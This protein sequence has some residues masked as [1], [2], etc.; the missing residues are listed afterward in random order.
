[1][2][3]WFEENWELG[4][5]RIGVFSAI[6]AIVLAIILSFVFHHF[7]KAAEAVKSAFTVVGALAIGFAAVIQL[8]RHQI[9]EDD[10]ERAEERAEREIAQAQSDSAAKFSERLSKAVSH[11]FDGTL[12]V[13]CGAIFEFRTLI[14]D[15]KLWENLD[16]IHAILETSI[17]DGLENIRKQGK[18]RPDKDIFLA[19]EALSCL[20]LKH[21]GKPGGRY[22]IDLK[23]LDGS[24]LDLKGIQLA[25][26]DLTRAKL[27]GANLYGANLESS[28]LISAELNGA[29]LDSAVLHDTN[30]LGAVDLTHVQ[31][32]KAELN[33]GT[34]LDS[35]LREKRDMLIKRIQQ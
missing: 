15:A 14:N 27:R 20:Y 12:P 3:D 26:A 7:E 35:G 34:V 18:S 28:L 22:R 21:A 9:L 17:K 16:M 13:R 23:G 24:G 30:L 8:R 25:G 1:M 29:I 11:F 32:V 5:F 2:R 31:L 4:W 10:A 6:G 33:E 19:A